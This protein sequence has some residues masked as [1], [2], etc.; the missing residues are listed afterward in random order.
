MT[1]AP[2]LAKKRQDQESLRFATH[3]RRRAPRDAAGGTPDAPLFS[4]SPRSQAT[5]GGLTPTARSPR[6]ASQAAALCE[7]L[8]ARMTLRLS[9]THTH[10]TP[11]HMYPLKC[12]PADL[13]K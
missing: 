6:P 1:R 10:I 12:A 13:A 2:P 3:S 7:A 8:Y 4:R 9:E 11:A 5:G